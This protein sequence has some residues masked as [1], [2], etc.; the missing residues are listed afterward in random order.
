MAVGAPASP[1]PT[2]APGREMQ[3]RGNFV[4]V[5]G[6]SMGSRPPL[7]EGKGQGDRE[8]SGPFRTPAIPPFLIGVKVSSGPKPSS[9]Y[10][11]F[12]TF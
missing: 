9:E 4:R 10:Q 5:E 1:G 12:K 8:V 3:A 11:G 2:H 7:W 6:F